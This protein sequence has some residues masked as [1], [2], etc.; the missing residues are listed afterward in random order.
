MKHFIPFR[1]AAK[2]IRDALVFRPDDRT[3]HR[4]LEGDKNMTFV[5]EHPR[6]KFYRRTAVVALAKR[7]AKEKGVKS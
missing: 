3:I 7:K 1:D 6:Y 5:V 4:W 2:I